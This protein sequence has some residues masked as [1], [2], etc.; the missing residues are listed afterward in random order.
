MDKN[1]LKT[2]QKC[3]RHWDKNFVIPEEHI[4]EFIFIA[5]NTPSK[6]HEAYYDLYVITEKELIEDLLEHTWGFTTRISEKI[7]REEVPAVNRN[8]QMGA[9]LYMLWVTK[10]PHT[11]RNFSRDGVARSRD[12][13]SRREN[14][15]T[16]VG[17]SMG[18][19]AYA[20]AEKGYVTGFNKNHEHPGKPDYWYE[21]LGIPKENLISYGVGIGKPD[22]RFKRHNDTT[23]ER[24]MVGYPDYDIIN[25]KDTF[26]VKHNGKDYEVRDEIVFPSFSDKERIINVKRF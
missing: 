13:V 6:Q 16:S 4:E 15:F 7:S 11:L 5:Q 20:A 26:S 10:Q 14:A 23:E 22:P 24:L 3:Q 17:M 18:L 21:R 1:H 19:V 12:A 2:I 25:V 9:S 8:P